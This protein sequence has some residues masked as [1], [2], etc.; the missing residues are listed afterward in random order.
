MAVIQESTPSCKSKNP[1]IRNYTTV[2]KDR[3]H[4]QEGGLLIFIHRSITFYKQPSSPE[5]LSDLE[6]LSIKAVLR[7]T[8]LIIFN[9]CIPPA[10]SCSNGYQSTIEHLLTIPDTLNLGDFNVHHLS[11]YSRSTD[12]RGRK[13]T[14]FISGI[15]NC[16]LGR[17]QTGTD[18]DRN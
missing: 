5:L 1:Y 2:C 9:V 14:E 6:K 3:P 13:M 16:K 18:T 10:S 12:T 4:D 17:R 11:G 8:M 15:L 7:N